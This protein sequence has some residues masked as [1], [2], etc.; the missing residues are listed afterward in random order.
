MSNVST[1]MFQKDKYL[2][3]NKRLDLAH[4]LDLSETQ[5]KTWFQNRR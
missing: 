3:V 1:Y 5:I 2:S 4:E